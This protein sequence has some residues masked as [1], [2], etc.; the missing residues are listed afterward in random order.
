MI[1]DAIMFFNELDILE[2]RLHELDSVVD[3]FVIVESLERHGS[4]EAKPSFIAGNW[5]VVKPFEH[6]LKYLCL[7]RLE[8]PHTS[9]DSSWPREN[10]HR[11]ALMDCLPEFASGSDLLMISDCDEIPRA[12]V[13]ASNFHVLRSG[14][15]SLNQ[16]MFYY[17][18]NNYIGKWNGTVIASVDEVMRQG[19]P[20][21]LR[22]RRD[23]WPH[24]D[25]SGWHFSYFGGFD[26]VMT[27][28]R[29]FAHA[30]EDAIQL[31]QCRPQADLIRD[32][33]SGADIYQRPGEGRKE[34]RDENDSRLPYWMRMNMRREFTEAGLIEKLEGLL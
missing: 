12:S 24:L 1:I 13:L 30:C 17:D 34:R 15:H 14:V 9:R 16:D 6:K 23:D 32:I 5:S 11:N 2:A 26:R 8:P 21:A 22:N 10:F 33:L 29:S 31:V 7:P 4:P 3:K 18:V 25:N 19:G 27:K 20:Q 28:L